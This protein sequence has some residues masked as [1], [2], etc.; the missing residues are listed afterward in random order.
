MF[1]ENSCGIGM[2]VS[3]NGRWRANLIIVIHRHTCR[4]RKIMTAPNN[5]TDKYTIMLL[6]W[7][8]CKFINNKI[9]ST[10]SST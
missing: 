4:G 3:E 2:D 6:V 7:V 5:M 9:I 8:A 1:M 10:E